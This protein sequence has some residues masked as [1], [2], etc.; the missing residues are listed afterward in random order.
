MTYQPFPQD[1]PAPSAA[2]VP[3]P[4]LDR[5]VARILDGLVVAV[6]YVVLTIAINIAVESRYVEAALTGIVLVVLQLGYFGYLES[7]RGQTIGKMVL[8]LRTVGPGGANPTMEQ[9]LLRNI[10]YAAGLLSI[11][12]FVGGF[13][14]G[15]VQLV[16]WITIAVGINADAARRQGW[17]DKVAGGTQVLK[18]G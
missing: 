1:R 15:L 4:L 10:F 17:H 5:F 2:G 8:K 3:A 9:A 6:P 7:A 11:A 12:P 16:A 18:Y 14:A 13:F